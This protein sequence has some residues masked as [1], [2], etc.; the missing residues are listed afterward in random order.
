M[1]WMKT[2]DLIGPRIP[3]GSLDIK[4]IGDSS[5]NTICLLGNRHK[6][7]SYL[8]MKRM[9]TT[10]RTTSISTCRPL[11]KNINQKIKYKFI[12]KE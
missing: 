3:A 9:Y 11:L 12:P 7:I 5:N 8:L 1:D 10:V 6:Y 4:D 2:K